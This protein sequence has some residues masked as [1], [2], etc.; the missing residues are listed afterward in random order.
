MASAALLDDVAGFF[1]G[2]LGLVAGAGSAVLDSPGIAAEVPYAGCYGTG[3]LLALFQFYPNRHH[4]H[5]EPAGGMVDALSENCKRKRG[6]RKAQF[7][8]TLYADNSRTSVVVVVVA[9]DH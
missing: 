6:N 4:Q 8:F 7:N 9:G 3:W 2:V 5:R 1:F